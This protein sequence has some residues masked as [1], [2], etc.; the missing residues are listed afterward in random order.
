MPFLT[1]A[2]INS[3][4]YP[5]IQS[6]I[7]RAEALLLQNA[8]DAA[9][10]EA[11]GYLSAYD[12]TTMLT[13]TGNARNPILLLYIKDIAVWHFI[14]LANPN[15]Q[16]DLRQLRY[17]K[18]IDWLRSVQKGITVPDLPRPLPDDEQPQA[19]NTVRYGNARPRINGY[20]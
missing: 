4:L 20:L 14:N 9:I 13:L 1:P 18:A 17:E 16:M 10:A 5:E 12:V 19:N 7:S 15:V 11:T 3:H 6:E 8:I 2:E